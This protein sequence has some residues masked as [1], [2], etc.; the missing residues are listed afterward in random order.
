MTCYNR[1]SRK[2]KDFKFLAYVI[3]GTDITGQPVNRKHPFCYNTQNECLFLCD[4][5]LRCFKTLSEHVSLLETR[6]GMECCEQ[7][8][9][10]RE[11]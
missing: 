7:N 2:R 11:T 8:S 10:L 9:S 1:R 6:D 5:V 4:C 3:L